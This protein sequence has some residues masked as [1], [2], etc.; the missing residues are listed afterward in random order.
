MNT[1]RDRDMQELLASETPPDHG[2]GFWESLRAD[3]HDE[4]GSDTVVDLDSRRRNR[5]WLLSAAAVVVLGAVVGF[6]LLRE[7]SDDVDVFTEPGVTDPTVDPE[8]PPSTPDSTEAPTETTEPD[9]NASGPLRPAG[10]A[11]DRGSGTVVGISPD[12]RWLYVADEVGDGERACEGAPRRALYVEPLDGSGDRV[13]AAPADQ[14]DATTLSELHFDGQGR[15][16]TVVQCEGFGARIIAASVGADG[17]L[18]QIEELTLPETE[19]HD[20]TVD[21]I[22]DL[23]YLSPG[24]LVAATSSFADGDPC[25][26]LYELPDQASEPTDLGQDDVYLVE[27]TSDGRLITATSDGQ[28]RLDGEEIA[29]TSD[30]VHDVDVSPDG[31]TVAIAGTLEVVFVPLDGGERT[32]IAHQAIAVALRD[33]DGGAGLV[34]DSGD[35]PVVAAIDTVDPDTVTQ[36]VDEGNPAFRFFFSP[37]GSRLFL[38]VNDDDGT[39]PRLVEQPV[40]R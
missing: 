32:T 1:D 19:C 4:A 10:E 28:V 14:L 9:D 3:L 38:T 22:T 2:A 25:R 34:I 12:G 40:T 37:D 39:N 29:R 24:I 18:T 17:T 7:P 31:T 5:L 23:D 6:G 13:Q 21:G 33:A 27:A 35:L 11:I 30:V 15:V 8:P 20:G 36:L 26:H 16:A